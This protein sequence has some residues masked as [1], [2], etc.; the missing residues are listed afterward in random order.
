[1]SIKQS[2]QCIN[3]FKFISSEPIY[4]F[5]RPTVMINNILC[6]NIL[7]NK[8]LLEVTSPAKQSATPKPPRMTETHEDLSIH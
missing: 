4:L 5:S 1:V 8:A 7:P 2:L 6:T 3:Q